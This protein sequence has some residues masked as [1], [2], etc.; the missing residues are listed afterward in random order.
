MSKTFRK[1]DHDDDSFSFYCIIS[2]ICFGN[3]EGKGRDRDTEEMT[4]GDG[5][6]T[7]EGKGERN[8]REGE[9]LWTGHD[10]VRWMR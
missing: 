5:D 7:R 10:M 1:R 8:H 9:G 4:C 2:L 3:R 6:E